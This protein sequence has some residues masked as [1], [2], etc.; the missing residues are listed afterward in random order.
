MGPLEIDKRI[1][2]VAYHLKLLE[3]LKIQL[4][5]LYVS[6][7]KP[8]KANCKVK[9]LSPP[10]IENEDISYEVERVLQHEVRGSWS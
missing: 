3:T 6:L 10:I 2:I 8:C 7:L 1:N 5:V 9:P 4:I